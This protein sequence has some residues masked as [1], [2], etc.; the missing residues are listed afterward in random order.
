MIT[1]RALFVAGAGGL[2]TGCD[3]LGNN[4]SFRALLKS[5]E[6]ANYGLHR[7]LVDIKE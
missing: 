5:G 7:M 2:V 1:R 3:A 6:N 4:P